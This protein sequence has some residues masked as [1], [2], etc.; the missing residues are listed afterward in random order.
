MSEE[1]DH[2]IV[3]MCTEC[4]TTIPT[5]TMAK[6]I[7]ASEGAPPVCKYC[8]GVVAVIDRRDEKSVKVQMDAARNLNRG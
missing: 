4:K 7:F 1:L 3:G 2:N 6:N 8:G 5:T